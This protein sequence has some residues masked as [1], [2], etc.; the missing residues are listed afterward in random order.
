M[1]VGEIFEHRH[2]LREQRDVC[3]ELGRLPKINGSSIDPH[4]LYSPF[5]HQPS[6]RLRM[7]PGKMQF[8][9]SLLSSQVRSQIVPPV[10][11]ESGIASVQQDNG[12]M[13]NP[14]MFC[15]PA[16]KIRD[17]HTIIPI[18][19]T[20]FYDINPHA[21]SHHTFDWNLVQCLLPFRKMNW[22]IDVRAA[23]LGHL[24]TI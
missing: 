5:M 18:M 22:G 11:P 24:Y 14:T 2:V 17:H 13:W 15:F 1:Q 23:M 12:V 10:W 16:L 19:S 20:L 21:C 3:F 4:G 9:Y 7:Q 8:P 6:C